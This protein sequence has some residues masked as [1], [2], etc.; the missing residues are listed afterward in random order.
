MKWHNSRMPPKVSWGVLFHDIREFYI[1][2]PLFD[3]NSRQ[4]YLR[5]IQ[6]TWNDIVYNRKCRVRAH[7]LNWFGPTLRKIDDWAESR[8]DAQPITFKLLF[9]KTYTRKYT[10]QRYKCDG[11]TIGE[12]YSWLPVNRIIWPIYTTTGESVVEHMEF[13]NKQRF[14]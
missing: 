9:R 1:K 11:K 13:F 7:L 14:K 3:R 10:T 12:F 2:A 8:E 4:W 6:R 5:K